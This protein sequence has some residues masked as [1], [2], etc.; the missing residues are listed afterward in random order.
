MLEIATW[1]KDGEYRLRI[2]QALSKSPRLPS[3]LADM[4]RA[5]RAS[6]SR[7][8]SDLKNKGL[9]I[10]TESDSRT[11]SYSITEVGRNAL[12]LIFGAEHAS[13]ELYGIHK[14]NKTKGILTKNIFTTYLP[15]SA[16]IYLSDHDKDVLYISRAKSGLELSY[17]PFWELLGVDRSL[18][19]DIKWCSQEKNSKFKNSIGAPGTDMIPILRGRELTELEVKLTVVPTNY[20]EKVTEMIVR[21]N[22]QFNLAERLCYYYSNK[23]PNPTTIEAL[24]NF[25]DNEYENQRPFICHGFWKTIDHTAYLDTSNTI[26]VIVIS[27]FA[28]LTILLN[29]RHDRNSVAT[30][31]GRV[32][33]RI[34]EWVNEFKNNNTITYKEDAQGS[35]DHLKNTIYLVD[36]INDLR[37]PLNSPRLD[38][39]DLLNILPLPSVE[40]LKPERRIDQSIIYTLARESSVPQKTLVERSSD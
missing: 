37:K 27:D 7:V 2:L 5:N 21:Q 24:K 29:S 32:L 10:D 22:T 39:A 38:F 40:K 31:I 8:L 36:H 26:D 13:Y 11:V 35:L 15:I 6:I 4:L 9:V 20:E 12:R 28:Y 16:A 1:V 17:K 25:V 30:R 23:L 33:G 34:V 3:E 18:L 14:H 19:H